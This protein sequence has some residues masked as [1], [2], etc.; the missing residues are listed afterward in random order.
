SPEARLIGHVDWDTEA[1]ASERVR[2]RA[3][4]ASRHRVVRNQ[5]V[6]VRDAEGPR[7][8]FLARVA[9]GPFFHR[10]APGGPA[11]DDYLLAELEIQGELVAGRPRD[12]NSRPAPGA[13][14]VALSAAEVSELYGFAGDMLLGAVTG[15]EELRV[16]L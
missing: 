11:A 2:L 8:G 5:Y 9:S 7:T 10:P 6:Q 15:Q 1:A 13:P 4:V 12:T 16:A 3:P 14:V